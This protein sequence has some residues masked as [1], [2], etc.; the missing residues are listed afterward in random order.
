MIYFWAIVIYLSMLIGISVYRSRMVKTQDDFMV[1]GR[2]VSAWFLIGTLV[3]TWIGA[4][5]LFGGA[6]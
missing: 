2:N 1:A 3:C 5:S 4:G 6:G